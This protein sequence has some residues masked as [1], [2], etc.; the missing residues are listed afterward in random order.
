VIALTK[1]VHG[2]RDASA[3]PFNTKDLTKTVKTI[4]TK[5][6]EELLSLKGMEPKRVDLILAGGI[7]LDEIA[8][9][10]G[11]KEVRPTEFA[12]RD[13]ILV[14]ELQHYHASFSKA[15]TFSLAEV[16]KRISTWS[17]DHVH[18]QTVRTHAE[19]LFDE[20]KS[21][22]KL[23]Q[24]WR[25]YLSA[26]AILHDVGEMVSHSHHSEHSEYIVKNAH[27]VGMH[28]WESNLIA[29]L[30]RHHKEEKM[31]EKA[32]KLP[33]DKKDELRMVFL[34]LLSLLQLADSMDRT[35]KYPLQLKQKKISVKKIE[36]FFKSKT[37]CD[38]E[39]LRFE[40]K[41]TLFELLFKR[42]IFLKRSGAGRRG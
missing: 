21:I 4:E 34:K 41:K 31:L 15:S 39:I 9:L 18:A 28:E 12:L 17:V 5:T 16:E 10:I 32:S 22:H 13:G 1:L 37:P 6:T 27:F 29:L 7:L 38:L 19:W 8:Q 26:A 14:D 25:H 30:C 35:H 23:D 40:Q 24:K 11:A 2:N 20:L 42:E 3:K 36:L 33:Y